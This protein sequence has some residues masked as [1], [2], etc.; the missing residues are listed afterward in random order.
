MRQYSPEE[1]YRRLPEIIEHLHRT[2]EKYV[3]KIK[4]GEAEA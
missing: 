4:P 1:A 3:R 2:E